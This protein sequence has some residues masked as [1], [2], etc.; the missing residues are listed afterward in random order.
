MRAN[1]TANCVP[2]SM[3]DS[4]PPD[5]E[6]FLVERRKLMAF[7]IKQWFEVLS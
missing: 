5:Y 4:D 7:K 1:L 2:A 6:E 3:L